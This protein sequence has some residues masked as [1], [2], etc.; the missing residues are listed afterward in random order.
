[1]SDPSERRRDGPLL[2]LAAAAAFAAAILAIRQ[3]SG[4]TSLGYRLAAAERE[5]EV[6]QREVARA[7]RRVAALRAPNAVLARRTSLRS[8]EPLAH[9]PKLPALPVVAVPS[10]APA[11][12][13]PPRASAPAAPGGAPSSAGPAAAP[14]PS[15][16]GLRTSN[17]APRAQ[18]IRRP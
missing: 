12:P 5:G 6:L 10:A 15:G 13:A 16:P 2:G 8:L 18:E 1:M 14:Q 4:T 9:Q 11:A 7:E 17:P 3:H